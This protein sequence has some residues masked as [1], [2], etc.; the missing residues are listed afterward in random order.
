MIPDSA[1]CFFNKDDL[2]HFL[3]VT[4]PVQISV[5][6]RKQFMLMKRGEKHV[7]IRE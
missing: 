5:S 4:F 7:L 3:S 2:V 6:F 1:F